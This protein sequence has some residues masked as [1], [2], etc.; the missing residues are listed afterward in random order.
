M[1]EAWVT[2]LTSSA[3][4]PLNYPTRLSA[5]RCCGMPPVPICRTNLGRG[6]DHPSCSITSDALFGL[7]PPAKGVMVSAVEFPDDSHP[8][9]TVRCPARS[10]PR[11]SANRLGHQLSM[12][13]DPC[14]GDVATSIGA[15]RAHRVG[16]SG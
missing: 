16:A 13:P 1:D 3:R 4:P 12:I 9:K 15:S 5:R 10:S 6:H 14:S 8:V 2:F 7:V 11:Q